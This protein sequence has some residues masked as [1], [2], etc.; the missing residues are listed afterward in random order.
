MSASIV[1]YPDA[2]LVKRAMMN[3]SPPP[4][5]TMPRWAVVL[6]TFGMGSTFSKELCRLHGLDP[7]QELTGSKLGDGP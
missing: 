2:E 3:I 5:H 6:R 1:M 4:G 7:D